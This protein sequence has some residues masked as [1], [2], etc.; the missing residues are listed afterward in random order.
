MDESFTHVDLESK[1]L[2]AERIEQ[3]KALF[4]EIA[5]EGDG[6]IDFEKLRLIL[7]DEVDEG[8]ER[9]AFTWPGKADA[10]RQAQTPST[11]TLRPDEKDSVDWDTTE[12]LYIE[13]D[14]LEVLKLL[15]RGYHGKVKMIYIDPP[16]NTG[17]DFVYKDSFQ[18]SIENYKGQAGLSGQ[19]NADTSGRYHSDW[20]SMM[21]PRLRLARELLTDDGV[22]FISIDDNE[23]SNLQSICNEIFGENNF[24]A[25]A[26]VKINPRGRNLDQFV[27]KTCEPVLIFAKDYLNPNTVKPIEKGSDMLAEYSREDQIGKY[28]PIGLRNRNQAFN[29]ITRPTMYYP[30]YINPDNGLVSLTQSEEYYIEIY[31]D[32]PDGTQTCWT[33]SKPKIIQE[34][35]LLFAENTSTGWRVFRKDYA[36]RN[37]ESPK[38]LAKS[39]WDEGE[40]NNDQGKSSIKALFGANV[41]DFPKS[42]FLMQR[43]IEMGTDKDSLILDFFSGS[44]TLAHACMTINAKDKGNRHFIMIQMPEKTDSNSTAYRN[45]LKTICE[46]GE[47][48]IRRAGQKIKTEIEEENKQLKLGEESKPIP[49]IGFRVL[50]LDSSNFDRVEGGVLVDNL[51]KLDRNHDDIIFE[52][53]LKWGLEL[54]LPMEK[55]EVAGYP[56]TSIAADELICCMDEGLTVEVLEAIAALEPKRVFFLD[57]V[58]TDTIKLNAAQIFKRVGDKLG[59]EIE[60]RTA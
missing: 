39:L 50:K 23:E 5:V 38:T 56:I 27:A 48:R 51:I 54:S 36:S 49:D 46:I 30:L 35:S 53:M 40:F 11:A 29:P 15:Q 25:K 4:P 10:I 8:Q 58:L 26:L 31:P 3:L 28:R 20:L 13:G 43:V 2:V 52:M 14:N 60:L 37:G 24:I 1:D 7:G 17:H 6:S 9:Y 18:D 41:M 57:S 19:S 22:I 55:T 44:A 21:Y 47:E 59:Y 34:N 32:A 16:Y 12:N 42:P 45:D 33:W